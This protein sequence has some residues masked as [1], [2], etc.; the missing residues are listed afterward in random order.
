MRNIDPSRIKTF[1][2]YFSD[3]SGQYVIIGGAACYLNLSEVPLPFRPTGD[4]DM[5]L[6]VEALTPAFFTA[7]RAFVHAGGYHRREQVGIQSRKYRFTNPIDDR[8]PMRIELF[9]RGSG[10]LEVGPGDRI[11]VVD[12]D[13]VSDLSA[14]IMDDDYYR[15]ATSGVKSR[16]G[17]SYL[18]ATHII[19]LKAK[20]YLN[21][22]AELKTGRISG[23]RERDVWKHADD[24]VSLARMVIP[25]ERLVVPGRVLVD[26]ESARRSILDEWTS[27]RLSESKESFA[28][29]FEFLSR[30]Y[31]A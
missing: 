13:G 31:H 18:S 28:T 14:I 9:A 4:I 24:I 20:A 17:I 6:I 8:F 30:I 16:D 25:N 2:E 15:L 22:L 12:P 11:A 7:F 27:G 5:I 3:F 21:N 19:L 10:S 1:V 29:V 26:F 23:L